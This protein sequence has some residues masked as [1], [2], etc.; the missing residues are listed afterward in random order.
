MAVS[1]LHIADTHVGVETH[2][3]LDPATGLNT[4][5]QDFTR[6]LDYAF[7]IAIDRSLDFVVLAGDAYKTCD[8][9]ATH[10]RALARCVQRLSSTGIPLV[11][12]VGNHDVPVAFGKANSVDIFRTL[13]L[14]GVHVAD[15]DCVIDIQTA[16]GLIQI[17]CL[18]WLH[19]S[20][21]L[22]TEDYKDLKEPEILQHLQQLGSRIIDG[23]AAQIDPTHPAILAAHV[24]V[25]DAV[26]SGSEQTAVIGR[27]PVFLTSTLA[28]SAFDYVA[29]GHIHRHQ[30]MN[31]DASPP[32]VYS[33]SIDR[34][35][36]GEEKETKGFCIVSIEQDETD[37]KK[38]TTYEFVPT[39][40]RHFSTIRVDIDNS[41]DPTRTI[42]NALADHDLK[43]KIIRV[44]Y[45]STDPIT[46]DFPKIRRATEDTALVAGIYPDTERTI[47]QR[48]S[49]VTQEMG[50]K[51]ALEAYID[52]TSR[53]ASL[54]EDMVSRA[55]ALEAEEL[56]E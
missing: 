1:F 55:L 22:A 32:V 34:L 49:T 48:R 13:E 51:K 41:T 47:R 16:S 18:P 27:D 50:L 21:L 17:A 19:R 44:I 7:D 39:P 23:L 33:G 25:A 30:N 40:S 38:H 31:P 10:Q 8:P 53:L 20:H 5:V 37:G 4:R 29:L 9:S 54:K 42:V 46:L 11:I 52:N 6:C 56:T 3:R 45:R 26:L 14:E 24:A 43:D 36:F 12:V 35:D 28:Q 2:G 15:S